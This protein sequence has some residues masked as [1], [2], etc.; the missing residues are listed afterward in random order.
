[1]TLRS[2]PTP[3]E[4]PMAIQGV[5]RDI[6]QPR[7]QDFFPFLKFENSPGNEVGYFLESHPGELTSRNTLIIVL[8]KVYY[9]YRQYARF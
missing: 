1:L 5:G 2:P 3:S 6:F 7:S 9:F 4:F 8:N